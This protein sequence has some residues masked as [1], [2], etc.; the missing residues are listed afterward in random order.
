MKSYKCLCCGKENLFRGYSYA[1]KYCN[2]Q[3]QKDFEYKQFIAEWKAGT[4]LGV[5]KNGPSKHIYRYILE[6]QNGKCAI[7]G[8][9]EHNGLPLVLE[10]DHIDGNHTNNEEK[11]LRH[12]CPNCHSQTDTYKNKNVGNGRQSRR[13]VLN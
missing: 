4:H 10:L 3:C 12:L 5:T 6:K 1:N 13:K 7:C 8:I 11:N 2:N 9:S